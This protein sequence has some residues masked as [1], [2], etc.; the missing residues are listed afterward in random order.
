MLESLYRVSSTMMKHN[1]IRSSM[2][3]PV[4]QRR[5]LMELHLIGCS[6]G[7]VNVRVSIPIRSFSD[8]DLFEKCER[9]QMRYA[10]LV[11]LICRNDSVGPL[12]IWGPARSGSYQ[13]DFGATL[14]LDSYTSRD[15]QNRPTLQFSRFPVILPQAIGSPFLRQKVASTVGL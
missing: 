14:R 11:I 9:N 10:M 5:D 1:L 8:S 7:T 4:K 2:C 15:D 12:T 13:T 6:F 3:T